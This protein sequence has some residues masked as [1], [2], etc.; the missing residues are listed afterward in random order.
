MVLAKV[1]QNI[2][3]YKSELN[4]A[5]LKNFLSLAKT[6]LSSVFQ[7]V[8]MC[9]ERGK[10]VVLPQ[11]LQPLASEAPLAFRLQPQA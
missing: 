1:C 4:E 3:L 8:V 5:F 2:C 11:G 6:A 7:G 10:D 9:E